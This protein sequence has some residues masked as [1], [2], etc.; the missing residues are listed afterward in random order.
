MRFQ[1]LYG[2]KLVFKQDDTKQK[3][4]ILKPKPDD[5]SCHQSISYFTKITIL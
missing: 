4:E 1:K 5:I 3:I 2:I